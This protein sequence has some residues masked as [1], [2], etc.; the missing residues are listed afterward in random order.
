MQLTRIFIAVIVSLWALFFL[1]SA[2]AFLNRNYYVP[3]E[4]DT[5]STPTNPIPEKSIPA[6]V[7][8]TTNPD[9]SKNLTIYGVVTTHFNVQG[10]GNCFSSQKYVIY[11]VTTRFQKLVGD[12]LEN[13]RDNYIDILLALIAFTT[14]PL[15]IFKR[16]VLMP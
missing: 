11:S 1:F 5:I 15:I 13:F 3:F 9:G 4:S 12:L 10:S 14:I 2:L 7:Q 8:L 6:S 16:K